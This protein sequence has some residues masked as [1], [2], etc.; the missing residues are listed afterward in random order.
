MHW[1]TRVALFFVISA[2]SSALLAIPY[3]SIQ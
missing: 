1:L 3:L 2:A